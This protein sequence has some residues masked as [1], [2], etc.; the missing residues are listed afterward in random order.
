MSS[1][2]RPHGTAARQDPLSFT[3]SWSLLKFMSIGSVML[4]NHL[5]LCSPLV[6]LPSIF[7]IIRIF[8]NELTLC[9]RWPKYWRLSFSI[10]PS[11]EYSVLISFTIAWFDLLAV[12]GTLKSLLQHHKSKASFLQ[13][14]VFF[15]VQLSD[16]YETTGKTKCG[17][18]SAKWCLFFLICF[19]RF[20]I[21]FLPKSKCL[22][23]SWLQSFYEFGQMD[24]DMH[25]PWWY[26]T[27]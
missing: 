20:A 13:H 8:S 18:L 6:L 25:P 19:S 21:A 14:S 26:H 11:S 27:E 12:Q 9:I 2:L 4:S 10:S 24:N 5:I 3:I 15:T 1:C 23:V 7:P 22:L 16:P 17:L